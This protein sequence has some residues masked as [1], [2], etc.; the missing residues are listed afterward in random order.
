M[1]ISELSGKEVINLGDG[2][3]LGT[4]D[5]CDLSFE[6]RTGHIQGLTLPKRHN[7]F[8]FF[9]DQNGS[10]IPWQAVRRVGDEVIIVDLNNAYDRRSI[11]SLAK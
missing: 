10:F 7:L 3:R 5:E 4:I 1:R 2:A 8:G 9:G 6:S 11:S